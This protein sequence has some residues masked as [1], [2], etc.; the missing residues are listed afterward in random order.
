MVLLNGGKEPGSLRMQWEALTENTPEPNVFLEPYQL[1]PALDAFGDGSIEVRTFRLDVGPEAV[2]ASAALLS[3]AERQR[4][5]RF[6]FDRDRRRF[7]VAR[8]ELRRL[9]SE[10]LG[11]HA[12]SVEFDYGA[13][14]KPRLGHHYVESNLRF[15]LS[16]SNELVIYAFSHGR[17]IGIDVERVRLIHDAYALAERFFSQ[18]EN[19]AYRALEPR[20]KLLG[21]FNCWTRKEAFVKALGKGLCHPLNCFDVSLAPGKP[22]RLLRLEGASGEASGWDMQSFHPAPGFVGA[23]VIE[24]GNRRADFA[25]SFTHVPAWETRD[26]VR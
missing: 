11:V 20:D 10:R 25:S 3:E 24:T 21:F 23:V 9:L 1:L 19:D 18:R 2:C 22:A 4:A 14:G 26:A 7:I 5:N 13:Y 15:N 16:H 8:A 6:A 12:T 17:E